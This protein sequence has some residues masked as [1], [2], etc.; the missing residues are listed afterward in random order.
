MYFNSLPCLNYHVDSA[1]P[2]LMCESVYVSAR[3]CVYLLCND[4]RGNYLCVHRC[5]LHLRL[6]YVQ[7]NCLQKVSM[8]TFVLTTAI[9]N[10]TV[11]ISLFIGLF[12]IE[13]IYRFAMGCKAVGSCFEDEIAANVFPFETCICFTQSGCVIMAKAYYR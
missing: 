12:I 3:V 9:Y 2:D 4:Q 5:S 10:S 1:N 11:F 6:L 8:H 7:E 13:F